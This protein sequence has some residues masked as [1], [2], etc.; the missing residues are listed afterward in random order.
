MDID[1][2]GP[3]FGAAVTTVVLA[4]VLITGSVWLLAWQT[5]AFALG[6]AGGVGRS[7]YGL[8]FR[9]AVRPRLGPPTEFEAPEPPRFAQAVGL[10]FAGV[11]LVGYALGPEWLGL[12]ATG[13]ALAAAFLN[14]A[15]GYCLGCEMYLLVRRATVRTE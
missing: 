9:A 14:A 5:L 11:G 15:F 2:R 7:P 3:R 8:L 6:A 10:V 12:T 13:A 4:V 1:A